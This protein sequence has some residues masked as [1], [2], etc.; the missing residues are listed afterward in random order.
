[1]YSNVDQFAI[2]LARMP[3]GQ[4][5]KFQM[6]AV[7]FFISKFFWTSNHNWKTHVAIYISSCKKICQIV[8]ELLTQHENVFPL[9]G[10]ISLLQR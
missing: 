2:S 8:F 6:A 10:L 9:G 5:Q 1:M 3:A 7:L 4:T